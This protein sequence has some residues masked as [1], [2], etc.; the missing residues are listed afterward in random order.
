MEYQEHD[1]SKNGQAHDGMGQNRIDL[2]VEIAVF[3]KNLPLFHLR[4]DVIDK[5]KALLISLQ[6]RSSVTEVHIALYVRSGLGLALLCHGG[7]DHFGKTPGAGGDGLHNGTAQQRGQQL[8]IDGG[9][10]PGVDVGLVQRHYHGNAQLQK[11]GGKEQTAAQIGTVDDVD[12]DIG[13]LVAHIVPGNAL[14]G[15]EGG[16]GVGAG[17]V[18][19]HQVG[20]TGI[21]ALD[22]G[23]FFLYGN[24]GPVANLFVR[25]GEGVI[26][27]RLAA[28]GVAGKRNSHKIF[29][30]CLRLS[31]ANR[32]FK[33]IK[34]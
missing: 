33:K 22:D 34:R 11:L 25:S 18:H 20:I 2:V 13:G 27:G 26:H 28:V 10:L 4:H 3:S 24:A 16:H 21:A 15:C 29:L 12:D 31:S 7:L 1:Q 30:L 32:A 23:H 19:S 8:G 17:Q 6:N 9:L 14:L 5:G